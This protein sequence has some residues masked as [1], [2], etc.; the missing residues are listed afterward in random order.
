MNYL[1][2]S[3]DIKDITIKLEE[4]LRKVNLVEYENKNDEEYD[5]R[6]IIRTAKQY[7]ITEHPLSK[8]D[9]H[10][11]KLYVIVL[12]S[13]MQ[14]DGKPVEDRLIFLSR[15]MEGCNININLMDVIQYGIN[16]DNQL[17]DE[18]VVQISRE[19]LQYNFVVDALIISSCDSKIESKSIEYIAEIASIL[20]ISN[21]DMK[22]LCN[23]SN[24]I[25]M[26]S[27]ENFEK[28]FD[29]TNNKL[30]YFIC[31]TKEF[32]QGLLCNNKNLFCFRGKNLIDLDVK[33]IINSKKVEI[34][35]AYIRLKG[36][37]IKLKDNDT[38]LINNCKF[39]LDTMII[40]KR[41]GWDDRIIDQDEYLLIENCS[42]V[43]IMNIDF[44][45]I[46]E[47]IKPTYNISKIRLCER[48]NLENI[49]F[50]DIYMHSSQSTSSYMFFE[51]VDNIKIHDLYTNNCY[52]QCGNYYDLSGGIVYAENAKEAQI[53]YC[54]FIN[55]SLHRYNRSGNYDINGENQGLIYGIKDIQNCESINSANLTAKEKR[56]TSSIWGRMY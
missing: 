26:Q 24:I 56:G 10:I 36:E 22:I 30:H 47:N 19:D 31:Y 16:I 43:N 15:I 8:N 50:N 41:R 46:G 21:D 18:F 4:I 27:K 3:N 48:V 20:N 14:Y 1:N 54:K 38:I 33:E 40:E 39:V 51:N 2:I 35:N 23:I 34:I 55:T 53:D 29:V 11:K 25:L 44:N 13:V 7:P 45:I 17:Y 52:L 12:S 42:N 6:H 32:V 49:K 28:N 37:E 9:D 5:I